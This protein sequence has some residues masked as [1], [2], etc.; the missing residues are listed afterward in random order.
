MLVA[1][2]SSLPD[3]LSMLLPFERRDKRLFS[4]NA[5]QISPR[6][7][8]LCYCISFLLPALLQ[9]QTRPLVDHHQHLFDPATV[10]LVSPKLL[11]SVTLPPELGELLQ[12]QV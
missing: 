10:A 4:S 7:Q 1:E 8:I 6:V 12:S 11:P 5:H 3:S 2:A 9:A